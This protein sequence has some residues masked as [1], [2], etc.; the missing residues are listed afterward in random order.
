M[1]VDITPL[2]ELSLLSNLSTLLL[3]LD[4]I[5]NTDI[6]FMDGYDGMVN[7][8]YYELSLYGNVFEDLSPLA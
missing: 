7:L 5:T 2:S 8:E 4:S 3:N 6:S 1:G